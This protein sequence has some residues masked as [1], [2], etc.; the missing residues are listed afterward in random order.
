MANNGQEA[1]DHL[2][3]AHKRV[4][5]GEHHAAYGVV[6]MNLEMPVMDG[7]T[8]LIHI[9]AA[10]TEGALLPQIVIAV[11]GNARQGQID[12]AVQ[13]GMNDGE[14][15]NKGGSGVRVRGG[16]GGVCS[17]VVAT[18]LHPAIFGTWQFHE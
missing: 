5:A 17:E 11:T 16:E 13:A 12:Q 8:A 1:L 3:D 4:Q 10:E 6:L 2:Y 9:R 14:Y 7:L 18:H 15:T